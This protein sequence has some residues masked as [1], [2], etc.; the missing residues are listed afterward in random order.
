VDLSYI[1]P[2]L[3]AST[4]GNVVPVRFGVVVCRRPVGV[5]DCRR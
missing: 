5:Y 3:C 1:A 2:L 4:R